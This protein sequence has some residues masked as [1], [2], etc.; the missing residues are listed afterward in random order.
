MVVQIDSREKAR[1]IEKILTDF[2]QA[3]I[4]YVVSKLYVGDYQNMD[5]PKTVVDRKQNLSEICYN[6]ASV[7]RERERFEKELEKAA[8]I[9]IKIIVLIEHGRGIHSIDDVSKWINPM[10]ARYKSAASGTYLA[11]RMHELEDKYDV[12][13]EFCDK[14]DTG[15]KILE[16]LGETDG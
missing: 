1:A 7:K 6:I 3:G 11:K 10:K 4:K 5:N 14:D 16:L 9:G 2:D 8:E 15:K 12:K 13:F